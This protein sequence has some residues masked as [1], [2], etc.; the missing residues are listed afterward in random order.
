[1]DLSEIREKFIEFSGREDLMNTDG[2]DN[3]ADFF[4]QQGQK[5]LDRLANIEKSEANSYIT[6]AAG[7][8]YG[9][10][11]NCR[12]V[13]EVWA[14]S[15]TTRL[16]LKYK[17]PQDLLLMY[18]KPVSG[19]D[20]GTPLY[21]TNALIRESP[22]DAEI[23]IE[24]FAGAQVQAN[25]GAFYPYNGVVIYPPVDEAYV[26]NVKGLYY[27]K[28]LI[29]DA[30]ENFWSV[31]YPMILITSALRQLE[32]VYR[33]SEGVKDWDAA[34]EKE[35]MLLDMDGVEGDIADSVEMQG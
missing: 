20:Q 33:N 22:D 12:A 25:V 34:L 30:D 11:E 14:K 6:L 3:G 1:M 32:V 17:K 18:S 26:I 5:Y 16:Q 8:Y 27:Q 10:V 29:L 13:K 9:F 23:T 24:Y 31:Q 21:W 2:S 15:S 19:I 35:M 28:E 7:E 4:I